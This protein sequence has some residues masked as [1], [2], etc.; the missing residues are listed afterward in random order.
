M[1]IVEIEIFL[2]DKVV[3]KIMVYNDGMFN[4]NLKDN[5]N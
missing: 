2:Y 5:V 4:F 3:K 1:S